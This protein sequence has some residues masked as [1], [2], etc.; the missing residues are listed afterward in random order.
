MHACFCGNTKIEDDERMRAA[1][2]GRAPHPALLVLL[3]PLTTG[4]LIHVLDVCGS[5]ES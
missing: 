3:P 1:A 5:D 2:P 4:L